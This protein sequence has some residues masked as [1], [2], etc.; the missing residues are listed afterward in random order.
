MADE[1]G[2]EPEAEPAVPLGEGDPIEGAPIARVA[3]R[4]TWGIERSEIR[5]KEGDVAIR[6]PEGPRE[7]AS[8]LDEIDI[9]YFE[10]RQEFVDAVRDVVGV[11]PVP[12]ID[13]E[14]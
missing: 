8:I 11:G 2:D 4:L 3:A 1:D 12:T 7:L 10:R 5:R 9:P 13:A 6:T 14:E